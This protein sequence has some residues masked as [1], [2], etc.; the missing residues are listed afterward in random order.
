M[1]LARA[2]LT[3]T[4]AGE[5]ANVLTLAGLSTTDTSGNLKEPLDRVFRALAVAEADLATAAVADGAE[6]RAVAYARYFVLVRATDALAGKMDVS[7][8]AASAKLR[9]QFENVRDRMQE[10]LIVARGY[11]LA[12]AGDG[13]S[14]IAPIP[15]AG[16]VSRSDYDAIAADADRVPPLFRAWGA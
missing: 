2:D 6:E 13:V 12:I 8:G 5:L 16:G 14:G 9:Q 10:A 15:Y 4:I 7:A 1:A 11:G 3:T